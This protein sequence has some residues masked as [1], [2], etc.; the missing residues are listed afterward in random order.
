[1][2]EQGDLKAL[3]DNLKVL[4]G[5]RYSLGVLKG[6]GFELWN[7]DGDIQLEIRCAAK[8]VFKARLQLA[9]G[10]PA[11]LYVENGD[12]GS[13]ES[14]C[15]EMIEAIFHGLRRSGG[16]GYEL[17]EEGRWIGVP[18]GG[19]PSPERMWYGMSIQKEFRTAEELQGVLQ[20]LEKF[21]TWRQYC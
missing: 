1:M 19:G 17:L 12:N 2:A 13:L 6:N 5:E 9:M 4:V 21:Q 8:T 7:R 11:E 14:R 16:P 18:P 20:D 15:R 3:R 10:F